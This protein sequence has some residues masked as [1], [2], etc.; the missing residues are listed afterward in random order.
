MTNNTTPS[1]STSS[2]D[3][4]REIRITKLNTL[5]SMGVDPYPV[6]S[7]RDFE[8]GTVKFWFDLVH[9][10]D[11]ALIISDETN[12]L[13]EHY[14][15]QAVFPPSL[16]ETL[17]EKVQMRHTARQMGIDP[18]ED[19]SIEET[20]FDDETLA[21]IRG[22]IPQNLKRTKEQKE[23]LFNDFLVY[24]SGSSDDSDDDENVQIAIAKNQRLTL[25]GRLKKTR[26]SGKIAF[27]VLEDESCPEGLQLVFKKDT[28]DQTLTQKLKNIFT[29]ENIQKT[30]ELS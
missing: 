26:V 13:L 30:L 1:K 2:I 21:Q 20:Q 4:Q 3:T 12:F 6:E 23:K 28:L 15:Y 19:I 24:K 5:R 29:P 9:K 10:F 7:Y 11:F 22:L 25:C 16:L 8:I 14:L 27:G 17:E 18:D